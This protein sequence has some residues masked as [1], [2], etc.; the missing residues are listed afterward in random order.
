M[1]FA[2]RKPEPAP[3]LAETIL[4][5]RGELESFI[6]AKVAA[7]KQTRDGASM[8]R[9]QLHHMLTRGDSCLC[10]ATMNLLAEETQ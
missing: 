4:R 6:D 3:D 1:A 7:L 2:K 8:P 10:R 9:E 5:M